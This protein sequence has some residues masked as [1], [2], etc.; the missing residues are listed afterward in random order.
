MHVELEEAQPELERRAEGRNR[1]FREIAGIAAMGNQVNQSSV[2]Q[3]SVRAA[4]Q[5]FII[6]GA[7]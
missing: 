6:V 4:A 1:I 2:V 3:T 5:P 7:A